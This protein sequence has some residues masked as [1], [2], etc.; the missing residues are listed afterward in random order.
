MSAHQDLKTVDRAVDDGV[1]LFQ[2][3][4]SRVW[5]ARI[6]HSSGKWL[7]LSTG[8]NDFEKA[9]QA[10]I[11]KRDEI[12]KLKQQGQVILTR[13]FRDVGKLTTKRLQ[14][15]LDAGVGKE[16]Y[17]HYI[18]AIDNYLIPCFGNT[19]I[20]SVDGAKLRELDKFRQDKL[21][22]VP[23]RSTIIQRHKP[24]RL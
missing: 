11:A 6:R 8:Q 5:Q 14:K 24:Q 12:L 16:V 19:H 3:A 7:V 10:A 1:V 18:Q 20:D 2:R 15:D 17:K 21:G 23:N 4:R 13:R 22:R 9:K